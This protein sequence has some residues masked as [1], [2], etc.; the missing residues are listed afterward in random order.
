MNRHII[1]TIVVLILAVGGVYFFLRSD[2]NEDIVPPSPEPSSPLPVSAS[3]RRMHIQEIAEASRAFDFSFEIPAGWQA[4]AIK[5]IEA[6]NIYDPKG[7][8]VNN[9]E[10]SQ[11]FIRYFRASGFLTL[12]TVSILSREE[13]T[14]IGRPAVDYM[15]EKKSGAADF[16]HQPAWRNRRPRVLDIRASDN[17]P[18]VFYVFG[19]RPELADEKFE[20]FLDSIKLG[21]EPAAIFYPIKN[22]PEGITKKPF[23]I[24]I[25]PKNSP[26]QPERFSGFHT[27][28]DVEI[29]P[30][31]LSQGIPIY[32][33]AAGRVLKST[34]AAGYGGVLAIEHR[35]AGERVVGIYGH[36]DP[37]SLVPLNHRVQDGERIGILGEANT[38]KTDF[39]RKH[40]H[41]GLYKGKGVALLGYVD[42]KDKLKQ[43]IDPV[44][45]LRQYTVVRP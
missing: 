24:F 10:K 28:V 36:L 1:S 25:T 32:S 4:E 42:D 20:E 15:I 23:G 37:A 16:P 38:S 27:G 5:E 14:V 33:I 8:G 7:E 19:K 31:D 30:F 2:N 9:L 40:L 44:D 6:I 12:S 13:K 35:V 41:F 18:S 45:F 3:V 26:I 34:R 39:N 29:E 11:I 43:W 17:N 22:F 21:G